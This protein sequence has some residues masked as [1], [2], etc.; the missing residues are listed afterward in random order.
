[1]GHHDVRDTVAG[2]DFRGEHRPRNPR[3]D[4]HAAHLRDHQPSRR[5]EDHAHREAPPLRRSHPS[6]R[7]GEGAAPAA[8]RDL[9][10]DADGAGARHLGDVERDAVRVRRLPDQPA[11]HAGPRRL[12]RRHLSRAH[13]RR[14]RGDAA[15]QPQ[16]RRGAHAPAVRGVQAPPHADLHRRQQVRPRRRRSAQAPRRRRG[17]SRDRL[18]SD[19]VAHPRERRVHRRLRPPA[20]ADLSLRAR[21][22]SWREPRRRQGRDARRPEPRR[23]ARQRGA[24]AAR[25]RHRA[26]RRG[27]ASLQREPRCSPARCRRCSSRAR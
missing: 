8:P 11:R 10:L 22:G 13:R 5:R 25:A 12:L 4:P 18:P 3:R 9:R 7:Y 26:A 20:Q 14:Q 2:L 1:M 16:G 17:R 23:H 21:R 15:R 27:G 24:R 6:R 19:H